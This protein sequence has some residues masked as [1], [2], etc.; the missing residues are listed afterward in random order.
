MGRFR[1]LIVDDEEDIRTIQSVQL[2]GKYEVVEACNGLDALEKL[3]RVQPDFVI[4][5]VMMPVMG[6]IETCRAIRNHPGFRDVPVLFLSVL[7]EAEARRTG[8]GAG[9]NLYIGKPFD[10]VELQKTVD[11]FLED[12]G[13]QPR[14][15]RFTLEDLERLD[16]GPAQ[17]H[18]AAEL[19]A[20]APATLP[21]RVMLVSENVRARETILETLQSE[22]DVVCASTCVQAVE[23]I[24]VHKPDLIVLDAALPARG[25][26]QLCG[27]L[28]QNRMYQSAPILFLLDRASDR[29]QEYCR[30]VGATDWAS[31]D[32]AEIQRKLRDCTRQPGF[33][34]RPKGLTTEV[35]FPG[36]K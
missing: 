29:T 4:L 15:K 35:R 27:L 1:V 19:A 21:A 33:A 17:A 5:D 26:F 3:D 28:R 18:P 30:Q 36:Q 32:P 6:G 23:R 14:P 20:A 24:I 31:L 34:V 12:S 2:S 16:A 22:F 9:A 10:P 25:A 7:A 13:A 11:F 8:Y